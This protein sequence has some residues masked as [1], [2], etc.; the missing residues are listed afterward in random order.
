MTGRPFG[1]L[2]AI[3][4]LC[5]AGAAAQ[6][7]PTAASVS[8]RPSIDIP[9]VGTPPKIEDF[10]NGTPPGVAVSDFRQREPHDQEASTE[11]TTAYLSY[12]DERLYVGFVCSARDPKSVRAHML[13][14]E[15]I[16]SD[17]WVAV[18][19]DTF[20]DRQR[21]Y[22]FGSTPLGIQLDG[23]VTDGQ[24]DDFSFDTLWY[25]H[26]RL[27]PTGYVVLIEVPFK[28]M[29][30]PGASG[31]QTWGVAL[32][33]AIPQNSEITFW[34]GITNNVNGF[35]GQYA[36]AQGFEGVSPGRNMQLIPYATFTGARFLD[37]TTPAFQDDV[38]G[39]VGLDA[40]AVLHDSLTVDLTANPDFSQVES[41]EPQVTI[42]QRFEVFFPEK[43]P[44]FIENAGFFSTPSTLFFSRRIRDPQFGGRLTGKA[45]SWALGALAIDDRAAGQ[46]L[47]L[48]DPAHG[49]R[50]FSGVFRALREF[51][52]QS[53]LGALVTLRDFAGSHNRVASMDTR[54]RLNPKWFVVGQAIA[55]ETRTL[56]G[57]ST[58]GGA[59]YASVER[60]GNTLSGNVS[61]TDF[62]PDFHTDLGFIP[63]TDIR[64]VE[65]FW[66]LRKRP[67]KGFTTS[68]GPNSYFLVDWDYKGVLQDWIVRFPFEMNFKGQTNLFLRHV[69]TGERFAGI[70]F[71]ERE[72]LVSFGTNYWKAL[73]AFIMYSFGT[74]PNYFPGP[75]LSPFLADFHDAFMGVTVL[76]VAGLRLDET[77]IYSALRSRSTGS[78]ESI[79]DNHIIRSRANYQFNRELSLRAIID[80][81]AVLP[82]STLVALDRT[83]HV[84]ADVLMTY[85]VHPGTAVY[86]G[87]TDG[88]DNVRLENGGVSPIPRPTTSTGRQVF[89]KTSYLFRF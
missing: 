84:T 5:P 63:R 32:A 33:R 88:F 21:S 18:L 70:M 66:A 34:P 25:T 35:V 87:F 75:G 23:I 40:K 52:N 51:P 26:G 60:S 69:Q 8:P 61:Y 82:N 80:Y 6:T 48:D 36:T 38:R 71:R 20:H 68:Y 67:K 10:L 81:N 64:R 78:R 13:K 44:F 45:G 30:F 27:T 65:S 3:F 73:S 57:E 12:D 29:R 9:R 59:L 47:P 62:S 55:T 41:D 74:R 72:T 15:D 31:P 24:N 85:L 19:L 56:A 39:R 28:S 89:V 22:L 58:S 77:Y 50:A 86:V 17:D 7:T 83:K 4:Y 49:D 1:L 43:R 11:R 79:F 53:R 16:F 2:A 42:N 37:R 76:P 46:A 54:M 14:R